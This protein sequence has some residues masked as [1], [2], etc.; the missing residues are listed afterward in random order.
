MIVARRRIIYKGLP[1][2]IAST[3]PC[4][5]CGDRTCDGTAPHDGLN[6]GMNQA[7]HTGNA[8]YCGPP[9]GV[10]HCPSC[11][12][13]A[14]CAEEIRQHAA[15][16]AICLSHVAELKDENTMLRGE[17]RELRHDAFRAGVC[18][19]LEAGR[20][21]EEIQAAVESIWLEESRTEDD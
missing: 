13:H 9:R 21:V 17:V 10:Y 7:E 11:R 6:A 14:G 5:T 2:T 20:S 15:K 1:A 3:E 18:L 16:R 19:K 12:A 8:N 4:P